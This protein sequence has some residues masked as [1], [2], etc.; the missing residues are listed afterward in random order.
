M[1]ACMHVCMYACMHTY[2]I[3][4]DLG[5]RHCPA[6]PVFLFEM[7]RS[8]FG[9]PDASTLGA[10][11]WNVGMIDPFSFAKTQESKVA[12]LAGHVNKWLQ[13]GPAVVGINEIHP[14]IANYLV[15]CLRAHHGLAVGIA[16]NDSDS[17]LWRTLSIL[18]S[19]RFSII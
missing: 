1:Y 4:A 5:S 9:T 7:A 11:C 12:E 13:D 16:T 15:Q 2:C 14:T 8:Y 3:H 19:I 17:L 6:S 10:T 18:L